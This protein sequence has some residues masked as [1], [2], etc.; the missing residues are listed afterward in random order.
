M[1]K[2]EIIEAGFVKHPP[3]LVDPA[4][5]ELTISATEILGA[6]TNQEL[7]ERN[8]AM[9]SRSKSVTETK[10]PVH[11]IE[12]IILCHEAGLYPPLAV[13]D[14]LAESLRKWQD[15]DGHTSM[16]AAMGLGTSGHAGNAMKEA[17]RKEWKDNLMEEFFRLSLM[18][19][20]TDEAVSVMIAGRLEGGGWNDSG[21]KI[22]QIK[23]D[24][25]LKYWKK[26]KKS[27]NP[28]LGCHDIHKKANDERKK[29][30]LTHYP[31]DT[32]SHLE[33]MKQYL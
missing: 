30:V 2:D 31:A 27:Y 10:N 19:K 26:V 3:D 17:I 16:E 1:S 32:Y 23:A 5:N 28:A 13:L 33:K 12:S 7:F 11:A 18:F 6:G 4:E 29:E 20:I 14:W 25:I 8:L 21:H 9:V 22:S 24:T 15:N